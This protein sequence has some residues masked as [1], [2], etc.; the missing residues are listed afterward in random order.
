LA[1]FLLDRENSELKHWLSPLD[2][3]GY[4]KTDADLRG[5]AFKTLQPD[6]K[7]ASLAAV[8]DALE[9][10]QGESENLTKE[11]SESSSDPVEGDDPGPP[12]GEGN[13]KP[14]VK[15]KSRKA[16]S[17]RLPRVRIEEVEDIDAESN[18]AQ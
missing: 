2:L 7:E 9:P 4:G 6:H 15:T 11:D 16:N 10:F 17:R 13:S 1:S 5:S 18:R 12:D 3:P 8:T 14:K